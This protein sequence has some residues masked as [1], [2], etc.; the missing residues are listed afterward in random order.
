MADS[1]LPQIDPDSQSSKVYIYVLQR[2]SD[3]AYLY[4][5]SAVNP[6][7][8]FYGHKKQTPYKEIREAFTKNDIRFVVITETDECSRIEVEAR[9]WLAFKTAGHPI[10]N[11][12]PA[13]AWKHYG[14]SPS[15]ETRRKLSIALK[16]RPR[17][18]EHNHKLALA[19]RGSKRKPHSLETRLKMSSSHKGQRQNLGRK[20][21]EETRQKMSRSHMGHPVS[22]ETRRKISQARKQR[23]EALRGAK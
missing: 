17:S 1:S 7:N 4:V 21:T 13:T 11:S 20:H 16:G 14:K 8:R 10:V 5:G 3:A 9:F 2:I 19:Q 23:L 18:D 6:R 12:D 15:E 22:E